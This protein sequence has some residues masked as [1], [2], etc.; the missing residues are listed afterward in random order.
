MKLSLSPTIEQ[1]TCAPS[2]DLPPVPAGVRPGDLIIETIAIDCNVPLPPEGEGW[3]LSS[4]K[5]GRAVWERQRIVHSE[6][7]GCD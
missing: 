1:L 2:P 4:Y 6:E 5:E 7:I 3:V